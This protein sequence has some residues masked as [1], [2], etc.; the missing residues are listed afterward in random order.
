LSKRR[1]LLR[2]S[3]IGTARLVG[4]QLNR[5]EFRQKLA[6]H[7][8]LPI[9]RVPV[10]RLFEIMNKASCLSLLSNAILL[11]NTFTS[12]IFGAAQAA[13]RVFSPRLCPRPASAVDHIM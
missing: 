12:A 10:G 3:M 9:R 11:Y 2:L 7:T 13:G 1:Y 5:G 8:S 6:R 4:L